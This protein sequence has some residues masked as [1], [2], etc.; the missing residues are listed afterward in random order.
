MFDTL[1]EVKL[2]MQIYLKVGV[3][4]NW[5]STLMSCIVAVAT[6]L[7]MVDWTDP[8]ALKTAILPILTVIWGVVQKDGDQTGNT[9][10]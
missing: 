9:V 4:M 5:K 7:V 8:A 2:A 3:I 10:E 6:Y 1:K